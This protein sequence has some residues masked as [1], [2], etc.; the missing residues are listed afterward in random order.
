M[1]IYAGHCASF[2]GD[3]RLDI[4]ARNRSTGELLV[5]P[6]SGAF[7][8]EQ[9]YGDPVVIGTGFD[10]FHRW[11]G[12]GDFTGDGRADVIT[13]TAD[14]Q[15]HLLVNQGGLNGL[16]TISTELVHI[17]GRLSPEIGYD[18]IALADLTGD[19]RC[20][21]FGRLEH[22]TQVHSMLNQ[23]FNGMETFAPPR[24]LA[25]I[26]EGEI[27]F[28]AAD[29]TGN[30]HPDLLLDLDNG[31]LVA[32]DLHAEGTDEDGNPVGKGRRYP[33]ASGWDDKI[34]ITITDIDGD[35]RP[36]LLG[37]TRDGTL[38]VHRHRGFDP[39]DPRAT[40]GEAEVVATGWRSFDIIG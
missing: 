10:E 12:A 14:E 40:F 7:K 17:G 20:D 29:V 30:G 37:L 26:G 15:V 35:G 23:G 21:V 33:V 39:D 2:N 31:E 4:L 38:V 24:P 22:T 34:M 16:D 3:G 36:D 27:P 28:G 11:I 9:T 19:G 32:Y 13:N 1:K 6:H 5:F 25:V 8:G 18:T